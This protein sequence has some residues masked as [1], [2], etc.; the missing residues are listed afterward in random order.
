MIYHAC[1][2]AEI[3]ATIDKWLSSQG[4]IVKL[5]TPEVRGAPP[6]KQLKYWEFQKLKSEYD[7]FFENKV[8]PE[9]EQLGSNGIL[10]II[11]S[12]NLYNAD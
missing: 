7:R 3:A 1:K 10:L 8:I 5:K 11:I 9:Y 6:I 2:E 12:D 4:Y